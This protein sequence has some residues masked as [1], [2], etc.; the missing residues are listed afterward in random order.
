MGT[1]VLF[2]RQ[3]A[4]CPT[5]VDMRNSSSNQ[6]TANQGT[7]EKESRPRQATRNTRQ[8]RATGMRVVVVHQYIVTS[9][10]RGGKQRK[11]RKQLTPVEQALLHFEGR[12]RLVNEACKKRLAVMEETLQRWR[13]RETAIIQTWLAEAVAELE[14]LRNHE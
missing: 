14:K 13:E 5:Q 3:C 9:T 7:A 8:H 10:G 6:G 4:T 11:K 12:M 2:D 1:C